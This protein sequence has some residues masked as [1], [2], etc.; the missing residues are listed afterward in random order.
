MLCDQVS[1]YWP[2]AADVETQRSIFFL[3]VS[4]CGTRV[5]P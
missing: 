3:T 1:G 2:P 4:L 5:L